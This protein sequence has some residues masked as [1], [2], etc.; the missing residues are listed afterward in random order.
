MTGFTKSA[1]GYI[2]ALP[3]HVRM[4]KCLKQLTTEALFS[5]NEEWNLSLSFF[6]YNYL[7]KQ[8]TFINDSRQL[9][10]LFSRWKYLLTCACGGFR[11]KLTGCMPTIM[12]SQLTLILTNMEKQFI[13]I[14][15]NYDYVWIIFARRR[16]TFRRL[17]FRN[18]DL[19]NYY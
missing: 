4:I 10:C 6:I 12:D 19:I 17:I 15:K 16:E 3:G 2:G 1:F 5:L 18:I 7:C 11:I 13:L 8:S 9:I 14:Y